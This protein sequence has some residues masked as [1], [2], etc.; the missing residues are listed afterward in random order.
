M[1]YTV[2]SDEKAS[3]SLCENDPV[4]SILQNIRLIVATRKG[5]VTM[6]RAF[7]TEQAY[8]D[9]PTSVA[10]TLAAADLREAIRIYEPRATLL[11]IR[12]EHN[13]AGESAIILEVE[14]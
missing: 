14:I 1:K 13:Q 3:F 7:G 11:D 12:M 4:K 10:E 2:R 9:K 5:T 8:I 6:Y